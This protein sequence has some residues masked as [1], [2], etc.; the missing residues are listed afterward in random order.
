MD[1]ARSKIQSATENVKPDAP[2]VIAIDDLSKVYRTG[3]IEVHALRGVSL[4][5][6]RGEM[7]AIMGQ[8][9][10]GKSTL[11]NIIGTLD[12]PSSGHYRLD[13]VPVEELEETELARLRNQKIGFVFQSFNLLSRHTALANVEVPLV[14]ARV[15]KGERSRRAA[16]ALRRVGLGDRMDHHPMFLDLHRSGMTVVL[17]THE[18]QVADYAQRTIRFRDGRIVA[19]EQKAE[20]PESDHERE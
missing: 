13:D 12:R 10:S 2:A 20:R 4:T 9:G 11:M 6:R 5:I 16:E 17:V 8:S 3:D 7:V 1:P 19:D 15:G 14:Y 18:S